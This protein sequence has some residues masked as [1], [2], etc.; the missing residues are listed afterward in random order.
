MNI[1][2]NIQRGRY[3]FWTLYIGVFAGMLVNWLAWI[4]AGWSELP[5]D[6]S[7][8]FIAAFIGVVALVS[9]PPVV[10]VFAIQAITQNDSKS[11]VDDE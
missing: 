4:I 10:G 6:M 7:A 1:S 8:K 2:I 9:V 5:S 3:Y 11:V